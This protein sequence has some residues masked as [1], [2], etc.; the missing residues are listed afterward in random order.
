M[1]DAF[2]EDANEPR[3]IAIR[4]WVDLVTL[5]LSL[6]AM[7]AAERLLRRPSLRAGPSR[8]Q[9]ATSGPLGRTFHSLSMRMFSLCKE[10]SCNL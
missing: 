4:A 9:S 8:G 10:S 7:G 3:A 5:D 6:P 1:S 2:G